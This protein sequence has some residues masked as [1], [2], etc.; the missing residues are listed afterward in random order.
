M[1]HMKTWSPIYKILC[2]SKNTKLRFTCKWLIVIDTEPTTF[3]V[4]AELMGKLKF[5]W[6]QELGHY[7]FLFIT[8]WNHK[9]LFQVGVTHLSLLIHLLHLP[10]FLSVLIW[11]TI[12][13]VNKTLLNWCY[14]V[15]GG[16]CCHQIY[17]SC[18]S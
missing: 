11:I 9:S 7:F 15:F 12:K 8:E 18:V 10:R 13:T 4:T 3:Q 1:V 6:L 14:S 17:G 5:V 2:M 16:H